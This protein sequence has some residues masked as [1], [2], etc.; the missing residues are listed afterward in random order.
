MSSDYSKSRACQSEAEYAYRSKR[1]LIFVK[2]EMKYTPNSWL[3]LLLGN[4]Y[5][6]DF[7]KTNFDSAFKD[8]FT[9]V[10]RHRKIENVDYTILNSIMTPSLIDNA[11]A[12]IKKLQEKKASAAQVKP[13]SGN[14]STPSASPIISSTQASDSNL[15]DK[16]SRAA[17]ESDRLVPIRTITPSSLNNKPSPQSSSP[18]LS[19]ISILRSQNT[20]I[21]TNDGLTERTDTATPALSTTENANRPDIRDEDFDHGELFDTNID[22][23]DL[24]PD[25]FDF[26]CDS[27]ES[28]DDDCDLHGKDRSSDV[29][30]SKMSSRYSWSS[31]STDPATDKSEKDS[32]DE[33]DTDPEIRSVLEQ[34][35][36]KQD[37]TTVH[38]KH[39]SCSS[40]PSATSSDVFWYQKKSIDEWTQQEVFKFLNEKNL[41]TMLVLFENDM[42]VNG[43]R[44]HELYSMLLPRS[45]EEFE[46]LKKKITSSPTTKISVAD[47][48]RFQQELEKLVPPLGNNESVICTVM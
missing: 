14:V 30:T 1:R 23:V 35:K 5:Y 44:L 41:S 4:N 38:A 33:V 45:E 8:L 17:S 15:K 26:N 21:I 43:K 34:S 19:Q 13:I 24:Y 3:G 22:T 36:K 20:S 18:S 11:A 48:K 10:H 2:V 31:I 25:D 6:I 40:L 37:H 42:I 29:R 46:I 16:D 7:T 27:D 12:I 47:Y 9:Q 28:S 39:R 32:S